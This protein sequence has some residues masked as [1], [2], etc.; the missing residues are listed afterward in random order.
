MPADVDE[1]PKLAILPA[2]DHDRDLAGLR[3]DHVSRLLQQRVVAGVLP[4][5]RKDLLLLQPVDLGGHLEQRR[6]GRTACQRPEPVRVRCTTLAIPTVP[7]SWQ[8]SPP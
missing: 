2:D 6:K 7:H 8:S 3:E 1:A 4:G 5:P